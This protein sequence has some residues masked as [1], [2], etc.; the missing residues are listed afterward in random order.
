MPIRRPFLLGTLAFA[1]SLA[2]LAHGQNLLVNGDFS[3]PVLAGF[4]DHLLGANELT[5][6]TVTVGNV[7][8]QSATYATFYT[9]RTEANQNPTVAPADPT[10]LI[11]LTGASS[12]GGIIMQDISSAL[13]GQT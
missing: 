1:L 13:S 10:Q 6:W 3:L 8:L 9:Q 12:S 7:S 4:Q 2:P 5:G 11:D